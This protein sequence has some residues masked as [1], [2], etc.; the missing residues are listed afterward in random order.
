MTSL[1]AWLGSLPLIAHYFHLITPVSLIVNLIAVPLSSL[2]LMCHLGSLICGDWLPWITELFNHS[3]WLWMK[4]MLAVCR[5]TAD[6]PGAYWFV[7]SPTW[8]EFILYYGALIAVF[9]VRTLSPRRRWWLAG[10]LSFLALSCGIERFWKSTDISLTVLHLNGGDALVFD[11]SGTTADLLVD[12]GNAFAAEFTVV[13]Y[14]QSLGWNRI[15]TLFITHGDVNH[16][17]GVQQAAQTFEVDRICA[18]SIPQR[19]PVY[20]R[21]IQEAQTK[22]HMIQPVHASDNLGSWT[23]L[24]PARHDRFAQADDAAVVLQGN[25]RGSRILL[26]SDLGPKGQAMLM[27]REL[28]L[29]ADIVVASLPSQ[30]EPLSDLLL[31]RI[32]PRLIIL[33]TSN[34][35]SA[36]IVSAPLRRRLAKRCIPVVYTADRGTVRLRFDKDCWKTE[37]MGEMQP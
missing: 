17:G 33:T 18:S 35:K 34:Q 7:R 27:E 16:V 15:P 23:V 24:H 9:A 31:S 2:A 8:L 10:A 22:P 29:R 13:P 26:L 37:V 19:S 5:W 12:A 32:Q 30:G 20:R 36:E 21:L 3:G 11:A 25:I 4:M 28:D 6:L 1:A 14:L